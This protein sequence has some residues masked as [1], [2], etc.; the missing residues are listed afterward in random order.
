MHFCPQNFI[1]RR[2]THFIVLLSVLLLSACKKSNEPGGDGPP[3]NYSGPIELTG[4]VVDE[5]GAPMPGATVKSDVQQ[6]TTDAKGTFVMQRLK[7]AEGNVVLVQ[8]SKAGYHS[9]VRR[10]T[11]AGGNNAAVRLTLKQKKVTHTLQ[12]AAGGTLTVAGGASVQIPAGAIVKADGTA[13][14]GVVNLAVTHID[15]A[16]PDFSLKIPGGD[17]SAIRADQSVVMLY[18]YGM[19][20]VEMESP[21]GDKL[22]LKT[23]KTSTVKFPIPVF[24]Q[25]TAPNTIPLWHFDNVAGVWKEEGQATRQGNFYTGTVGHFSTWNVDAPE[26]TAMVEGFVNDPCRSAS[27]GV[28]GANVTLGQITVT[29]DKDGKF[30]ARVPAN[31]AT[32]VRLD[33]RLNN[34]RGT[35]AD[36]PAMAA[37]KSM[38]QNL[39]FPCGPSLSGKLTDCEGRPYAGFV[40]I[41]LDGKHIGS[42]YTNDQS[43]FTIYGP[44]GKTVLLKAFDMLGG[45]AELTVAIPADESGKEL[46]DVR[47]CLRENM[48]PVRFRIHGGGYNQQQIQ[49]GG[50]AGQTFVAMALYD[51]RSHETLCTMVAGTHQLTLNFEG[52]TVGNYEDVTMVLELNG[53]RYVSETMK[54][55]ISAFGQVGE[56]LQG[57]FSGVA[58][59]FGGTATVTIS[60]G[61]F[62]ALR[63][64]AQ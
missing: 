31:S 19:V 35:T 42:A 16:D 28:G 20:D 10:V 43:Q 45:S 7:L 25:A 14:T 49:I 58:E 63:I 12:S 23:G 24:Q 8:G 3:G 30:K 18:S 47:I 37:G 1:R 29:T 52:E 4:I 50:V 32:T 54:V 11:T 33:P 64:A 60:S 41:Y 51:F 34:G 61:T 57:T 44:K 17:L 26:V 21:S 27:K 2:R 56:K 39:S 55:G 15:P 46:G 38:T 13:Y 59:E 6:V 36:I 9:Q 22:Q 62:E 53:K 40:N 48:A 5:S